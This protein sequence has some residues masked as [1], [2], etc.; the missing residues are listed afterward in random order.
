MKIRSIL[1]LLTVLAMGCQCSTSSAQKKNTIISKV[2]HAKGN[3]ETDTLWVSQND[4]AVFKAEETIQ[5]RHHR[6]AVLMMQYELR[7]PRDGAYYFIYNEDQQLI[8]EGVYTASYT[9]E[10]SINKQG[11]FYNVKNYRYNDN[12]SL[13]AIHYQEDGR[14]L[15]I[16]FYDQNRQ[17]TQI[18]WFN[19]KSSDKEKVEFYRN[20][21][22]KET[23]IYT[24]FDTYHTL[25]SIN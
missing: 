18:T 21:K 22:L 12:G 24:A 19:K 20:G 13:K 17:L 23:R 10:G 16:E 11:N 2:Y 6:D 7:N 9:Y 3:D 14:N 5:R 15:K 1:I 4:T 25:P 8:Q